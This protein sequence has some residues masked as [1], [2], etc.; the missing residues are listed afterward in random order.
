MSYPATPLP[1]PLVHAVFGTMHARRL[2]VPKARLRR[3]DLTH[4]RRA[5]WRTTADPPTDMTVLRLLSEQTPGSWISHASALRFYGVEYVGTDTRLHLS[6]PRGSRAPR[7]FGVVG[8]QRNMS[9]AETRMIGETRVSTPAR[10]W[11][12]VAQYA[13]VNELVAVGDSLVRRPRYR[14]E[15]RHEPWC[16]IEDLKAE[17]RA[18]P[19]TRGIRRARKAIALIRVGA[20]SVPE[21]RLRLAMGRAG[22]PEPCLQ[23]P[24][25]PNDPYSHTTDLGYPELKIAIQYDGA[26]HFSPQEQARDAARD[27]AFRSAGWTVLHANRVDNAQDFQSFIQRLWATVRERASGPRRAQTE[28]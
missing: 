12:E 23:V 13:S 9:E 14:Y 11:L 19:H 8:H 25:D 20:D 4:V 22:L 10:A 3:R 16:T 28:Q 18:H 1:A 15:G 6:R 7:K 26:I 24:L 17:I 21:T 27:H 5:V 2:G